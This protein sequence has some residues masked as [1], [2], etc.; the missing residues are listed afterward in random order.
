MRFFRFDI[1]IIILALI[2]SCKKGGNQEGENKIIGAG[3]V[4]D[5]EWMLNEPYEGVDLGLSVIWGNSNIGAISIADYGNYYSWGELE[6][7]SKEYEKGYTSS[8]YSFLNSQLIK[9]CTDPEYGTVDGLK[10]LSLSDDISNVRLGEL[11]RIPLDSEWRELINP[12]N[13][14]W[15]W[16]VLNGVKG[17][18]VRSNIEGFTDNWIF[19]PAGG[20]MDGDAALDPGESGSYW[21]SSLFVHCPLYAKCT[22]FTQ[23]AVYTCRAHRRVGKSIRPVYGVP[24]NRESGIQI[25]NESFN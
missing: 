18:R 25:G 15:T 16:T 23:S 10:T 9:Y 1:I 20:E 14:S 11:W 5:N 7:K 4:T 8:S 24:Q 3:A 22:D 21:S 13:C 19:L 6:T 17:Y 2:V 12:K